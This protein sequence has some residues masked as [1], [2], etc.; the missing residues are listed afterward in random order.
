MFTLVKER[1][2]KEVIKREYEQEQSG[3]SETVFMKA[4]VK[5]GWKCVCVGGGGVNPFRS[6]RSQLFFLDCSEI[7]LFISYYVP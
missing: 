3:M 7:F 5:R 1:T 4:W 6:L 2:W